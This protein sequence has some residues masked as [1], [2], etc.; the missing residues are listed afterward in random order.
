MV[1]PGAVRLPLPPSDATIHVNVNNSL[2]AYFYQSR[3][4]VSG[5]WVIKWVDK[6]KWVTWV[7]GQYRKTLDP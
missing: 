4:W 1:S 2:T 6:C 3:Q 7:T 5:P